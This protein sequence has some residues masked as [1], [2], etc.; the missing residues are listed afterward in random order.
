MKELTISV[1]L[2][3]CNGDAFNVG[4]LLT[5]AMWFFKNVCG[6]KRKQNKNKKRQKQHQT[7]HSDYILCNIYFF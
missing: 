1:H 4:T 3:L 2:I 7:E 6:L 5:P